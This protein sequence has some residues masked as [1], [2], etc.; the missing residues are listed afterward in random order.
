MNPEILFPDVFASMPDSCH[1]SLVVFEGPAEEI[2]TQLRLLPTSPQ[3]LILP[4]LQ[5][6]MRNFD[7]DKTFDPKEYIRR[8][9][10]AA[11]LRN[12]AAR[13]FLH[14]STPESKRLVFANGGTPSAHAL[15]IR[16]IAENETENDLQ[17]AHKRFKHLTRD[18][19][20]G[21]DAKGDAG[22]LANDMIYQDHG[23]LDDPASIAMR[24]ADALDRL[25][26]SLDPENDERALRRSR[27]RS[28]S[29]PL[30]G[31][32]D[33]FGDAVP[34]YVFGAPPQETGR[35]LGRDANLDCAVSEDLDHADEALSMSRVPSCIG[36]AY[37]PLS[38]LSA[39]DSDLK[40]ALS[41]SSALRSI[42]KVVF[43]RASLVDIRQFALRRTVRRSKSLDRDA[44]RKHFP[45]PG[46]GTSGPIVREMGAGRPRSCLQLGKDG[47][48]SAHSS[49]VFELRNG[50]KSDSSSAQWKA[51]FQENA[52]AET[53]YVDRGTDAQDITRPE[54]PFEA[55]LPCVEDV[56]IHF[57]DGRCDALLESLLSSFRES[58]SSMSS[59]ETLSDDDD[60]TDIPRTPESRHFGLH[61][62]ESEPSI[63]QSTE[64]DEYDPFAYIHAPKQAE[65][66]P[67]GMNPVMRAACPPTPAQTPPPIL[68]D[69]GERFHEFSIIEFQTAVAIQNGLRSVLNHYFPA[70]MQGYHQFRFSVLPELDH[71][72]K[73]L[74]WS[75]STSPGDKKLDLL[76]AVGSQRGVQKQYVS[77]IVGRLEKL[78]TKPS[79]AHRS[80]RLDFR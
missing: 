24:A 11:A 61:Q 60:I 52:S 8:V 6:Y 29:L 48:L 14:D 9:H 35:D 22:F 40:T 4:R 16:A 75:D 58:M 70:H 63:A 41:E 34:F 17:L 30:Y 12:E 66:K 53:M 50:L 46:S 42:D 68:D 23:G 2:S 38:M 47:L 71:L 27:P 44:P 10:D 3:I 13:E 36:E 76:L 21:L 79:G 19:L 32:V 67:L 33:N 15:C 62:P 80:G 57:N 73:P 26:A 77:Q 74:F 78:G 43:G 51:S 56:V 5:N 37:R 54:P 18:G 20:G 64:A 39:Y 25:T 7:S 45:S 28:T 72:W 59:S 1:G 55:I 69:I 49:C 65:R 31:F